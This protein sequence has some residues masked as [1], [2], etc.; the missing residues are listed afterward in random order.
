MS[1]SFVSVWMLSSNQQT[2]DKPNCK[3][4]QSNQKYEYPFGKL[5][6]VKIDCTTPVSDVECQG[7]FYDCGL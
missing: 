7:E 3:C 4:Y 1:P 5:H 6:E 2:K